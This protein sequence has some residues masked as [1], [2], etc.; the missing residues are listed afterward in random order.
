MNYA[1]LPEAAATKLLEWCGLKS[2]DDVRERFDR[3]AQFDAKTPSL[4]YDGSRPTSVSAQRA[5]RLF[6]PHVAF[7][8]QHYE[9]LETNR[10]V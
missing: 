4:P 6:A 1:E 5:R 9:Q 3:V 2:D 10:R 7:I 8:A